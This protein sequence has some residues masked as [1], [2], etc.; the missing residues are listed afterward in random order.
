MSVY[1]KNSFYSPLKPGPP[2][3]INKNNILYLAFV[4]L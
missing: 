2:L 1:K 3:S 4:G